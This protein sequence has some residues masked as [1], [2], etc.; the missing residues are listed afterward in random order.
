MDQGHFMSL[1]SLCRDEDV[2]MMHLAQPDAGVS[3]TPGTHCI[4]PGDKASA[5]PLV[6]EHLVGQRFFCKK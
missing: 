6:K 5:L 1:F 2:N 4:P 3:V